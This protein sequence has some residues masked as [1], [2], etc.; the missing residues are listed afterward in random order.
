LRRFRFRFLRSLLHLELLL[1]VSMVAAWGVYRF[2]PAPAPIAAEKLNPHLISNYQIL[3]AVK[4]QISRLDADTGEPDWQQKLVSLPATRPEKPFLQAIMRLEQARKLQNREIP[5][6]MPRFLRTISSRNPFLWQEK[7]EL[8]Y[9]WLDHSRQYAKMAERNQIHPPRSPALRIRV[10]K[11][12]ARTEGAD[13]A[14]PLLHELFPRTSLGRILEGLPIKLQRELKTAVTTRDWEARFQHLAGLGRWS[15]IIQEARNCTDNNITQY[16]HAAYQYRR[17]HFNQCR[18]HL[19][20]VN[21]PRFSARKKA[22][23]IKMDIRAGRTADIWQRIGALAAEPRTHAD[24]LEDV[25]G[26]FLVDNQLDHASR[27]Y[28]KLVQVTAKKDTRHWKALWVNAWIRIKQYRIK[29]ARR[30]FQRGTHAPE[31][32]YRVASTFWYRHL[33]G[34]KEFPL[35]SAPF[36][37]YFVRTEKDHIPGLQRGLQTFAARLDSAIA[38]ETERHLQRSLALME[39]GLVKPARNYLEWAR[40]SVPPHSADAALLT[41]TI[42]LLEIRLNRHYHAFVAYRKGFPDYH[43]MRL[44]RFLRHILCPLEFTE[45]IARHSRDHD[46]DPFLVSALI[47]EESMFRPDSRSQSNAFGLM[48]MLPSTYAHI[49]GKRLTSRL[50]RELVQ[51]AINIRWGTRYLRQLLDKYDNRI[52]LALAAYNAGDH[53]ADRWLRQFGDVSEEQFIEMIPFSETRNYVKNILRNR[54]FYAFYHADAFGER[55]F[56]AP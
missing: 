42:S 17:R 6:Q 20:R 55:D 32:G 43:A 48:Q 52:Y 2:V 26:L 9:R 34:E 15:Q 18:R 39:S 23:C 33:G 44:P 41:L 56:P 54:F 36:T 45:I 4:R 38:P 14:S 21:H 5:A 25:A 51:P 10:L 7:N 27:A 3:R 19:D 35:I 16:Y 40:A 13:A 46:L 30:L 47:R 28:T 37:Y 8:I 11:A 49:S 31:P 1:V 12:L 24:L 50:R 53:R 29:E 22:L